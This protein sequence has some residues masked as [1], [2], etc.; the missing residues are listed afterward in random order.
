MS[1]I[2]FNWK[3]KIKYKVLFLKSIINNNVLLNELN[4]TYDYY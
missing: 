2:M 1:I 3:K 4:A